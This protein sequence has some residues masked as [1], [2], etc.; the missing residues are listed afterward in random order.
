MQRLVISAILLAVAIGLGSLAL[1]A[2]Q[3]R[4]QVI[5]GGLAL[6][7]ALTA[8]GAL[9][10]PVPG[11]P[12]PLDPSLRIYVASGD[13]L[14]AVQA[15]TGEAAWT[16]H[17]SGPAQPPTVVDG[18]VYF[19]VAVLP[20]TDSAVVYALNAS[21]GSQRW[22]VQVDGHIVHCAPAAGDGVVYITSTSG[23]DALNADDG[24]QRWR[25][26]LASSSTNP[27]S[28][29]LANGMLFFGAGWA[30]SGAPIGPP[31]GA[32]PLGLY[33]LRASD[34]A[35]VWTRPT[36][37][38]VFD[39]PTVVDGIVYASEFADG[40]MALRASDGKLLWSRK[41]L[42][43]AGSPAAANGVVYLDAFDQRAY[44]LSASDGNQLW[45]T[46]EGEVG[47]SA[48]ASSIMSTA[49]SNGVDYVA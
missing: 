44:A 40:I 18:V 34:G 29:A 38:Q 23:V 47:P 5:R 28:P 17:A 43:S 22:H 13:D 37:D 32:G 19:V 7:L 3:R 11:T 10:W 42:I 30:E 46:G 8:A 31:Q 6:A 49:T 36:G 16:F 4:K 9:W 2:S 14:L 45:Q 33:A 15:S 21:D 41:D 25:V 39:T 20:S 24:S 35:V 12:A 27:S 26:D 48:N 1:R